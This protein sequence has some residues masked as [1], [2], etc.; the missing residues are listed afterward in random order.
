[1]CVCVQPGVCVWEIFSMAQQP[2]FWLEN[3]Q[4]ITQLETGVRLHK[5]QLCPPIV[6]SLL[7]RCWAYE[8]SGRPSFGELACSLRCS[9]NWTHDPQYLQKDWYHYSKLYK[10]MMPVFNSDIHRMEVELEKDERR[11]KPRSNSIAFDPNHT[12]PPPKVPHMHQYENLR[13]SKL[14]PAAVFK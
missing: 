5:P 3:G 2:F 10:L 1:M 7:T 13:G 9:P 14:C 4:V 8:P 11:N 6:Y 12:E